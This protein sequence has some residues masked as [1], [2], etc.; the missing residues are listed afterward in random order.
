MDR[1]APQFQVNDADRLLRNE[2]ARLTFQIFSKF[3]VPLESETS[4]LSVRR[5]D[6]TIASFIAKLANEKTDE[7]TNVS[8]TSLSSTPNANGRSQDVVT[9]QGL[10]K[11]VK[12][13]MRIINF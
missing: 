13:P 2:S 9:C 3:S 6:A 8:G 4:I 11:R 5:L 10:V 7:N 12:E 1:G